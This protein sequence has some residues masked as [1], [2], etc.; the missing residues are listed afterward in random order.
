VL[1]ALAGFTAALGACVESEQEE[2]LEE[3][4]EDSMLPPPV[5]P[6]EAA[7]ME[8][9]LVNARLNEFSITLDRD[10]MA[11]GQITFRVENAGTVIHSFVVEPT[12][13]MEYDEEEWE[14]D[15]ILVGQTRTLN[16]QLQPGTYRIYCSK[17]GDRGEHDE[18]GMR[19]TLVVR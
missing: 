12:T 13:Q 19:A 7:A 11:A 3:M 15:D 17:D 10:S 6:A 18:L 9:E 2:T 8:G 14:I 1:L 4:A 5:A 16:L